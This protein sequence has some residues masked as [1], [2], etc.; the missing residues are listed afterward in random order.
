MPKLSPNNGRDQIIVKTLV[1]HYQ[2]IQII[3]MCY[4]LRNFHF[5]RHI[6][7]FSGFT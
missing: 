5:R 7:R 1:Q 4:F 3:I 2:I 6:G